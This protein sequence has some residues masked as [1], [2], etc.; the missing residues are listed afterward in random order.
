[1]REFTAVDG[2]SWTGSVAEEEGT[3][4]KGRFYLILVQKEGGRR[5]EVRDV[6][7]NSER[8]ARRTLETMSVLELRR[9]LRTAVGRSSATVA[10]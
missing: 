5:V 10:P 2:E 8:S 9:K 1:M 7:W 3:D 6:R 4:Y